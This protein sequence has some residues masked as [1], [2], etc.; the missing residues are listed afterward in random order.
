MLDTDI[1][2]LIDTK[3]VKYIS[4]DENKFKREVR[5]LLSLKHEIVAQIGTS[6]NHQAEHAEAR[7]G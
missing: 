1:L 7:K 6:L 5:A 4:A 2:I 3:I